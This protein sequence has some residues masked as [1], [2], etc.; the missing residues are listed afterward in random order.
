MVTWKEL[1]L[2][3]TAMQK[4]DIAV[5]AGVA[6]LVWAMVG[7]SPAQNDSIHWFSNYQEALQE[8]QRT[9]KPIFLEYRCE[10]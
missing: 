1:A 4:R 2:A 3:I 5:Q 6:C 7:P 10:P 9:K 8:A